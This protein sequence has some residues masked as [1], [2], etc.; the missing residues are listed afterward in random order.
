MKRAVVIG[1]RSG[2]RKHTTKA[3]WNVTYLEAWTKSKPSQKVLESLVKK[4]DVV[5]LMTDACSHQNMY[6]ARKVSK[7][8]NKPIHYLKRAGAK[9]IMQRIQE[10]THKKPFF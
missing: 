5:F 1:S 9:S 6:Q 7:R 8:Y 10:R 4:S 3:D 2:Q